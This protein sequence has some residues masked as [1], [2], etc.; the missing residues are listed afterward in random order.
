MSTPAPGPNPDLHTL[1]PLPGTW[2]LTGDA[3]GRTRYG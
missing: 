2:D 3:T 1:S